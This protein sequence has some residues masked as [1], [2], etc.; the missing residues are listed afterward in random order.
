MIPDDDFILRAR[1]VSEELF[2]V[3][4]NEPAGE[5]SGELAPVLVSFAGRID[6]LTFLR[7]VPTGTSRA[8][9]ERLAEA[10]CAAHP[11]PPAIELDSDD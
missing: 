5:G 2:R 1:V 10:Y 8:E 9:L 4:C 7:T 6:A 3:L 11:M